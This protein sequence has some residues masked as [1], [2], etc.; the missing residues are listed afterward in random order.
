MRRS[1]LRHWNARNRS[2]EN[3]VSATNAGSPAIPKI[4]TA[5]GERARVVRDAGRPVDI[6]RRDDRIDDQLADV[7]HAGRQQS[8]RAGQQRYGDREPAMRRPDE[9]ERPPAVPPDP[10]IAI[11][12]C[13]HR[14]TAIASATIL[15]R[16][17]PD[18]ERIVP[19]ITA[20][21]E[22]PQRSG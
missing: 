9:R 22:G 5:H 3:F 8:G 11:E 1:G 14:L 2:P 15:P 10:E 19:T 16:L 21:G 18:C 7:S 20:G 6:E 12:P 17:C 4:T 13:R